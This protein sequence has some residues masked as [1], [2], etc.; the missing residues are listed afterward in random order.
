[1]S[2]TSHRQSSVGK[3]DFFFL[4]R[5]AH[6]RFSSI[7]TFPMPVDLRLGSSG[8]ARVI[9]VP[10]WFRSSSRVRLLYHPNPSTY[11]IH[12]CLS[13][14]RVFLSVYHALVVPRLFPD[15][16][17]HF[18]HTFSFSGATSF[19]F[20]CHQRRGWGWVDR[21]RSECLKTFTLNVYPA[22]MTCRL[23]VCLSLV[24]SVVSKCRIVM[25]VC[26]GATTLYI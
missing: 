11:N 8:R 4:S 23:D 10:A 13:D 14:P 18:Y 26:L 3:T 12:S 5:R 24:R 25:V 16:A 7:S 15:S 9:G 17:Y 20:S 6:T 19:F 22:E 2:S 1:L 21:S